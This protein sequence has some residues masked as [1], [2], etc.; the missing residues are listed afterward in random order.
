M[1]RSIATNRTVASARGV[2]S[3]RAI[4]S[5]RSIVEPGES[6]VAL[7]NLV[8]H[9]RLDE[10]SG[11]RVDVHGG[12]DLTAVNSPGSAAGKIGDAAL[13][14]AGDSHHLIRATEG[15]LN[16]HDTDW[17]LAAWV[18]VSRTD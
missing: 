11:T 8:A 13:F 4:A 2:A 15:A 18:K 16:F 14:D 10:G 12:L 3:G 1:A 7:T 5:G 6:M 9:W 17:T